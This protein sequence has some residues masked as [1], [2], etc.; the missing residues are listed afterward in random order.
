MKVLYYSA[1]NIRMILNFALLM[2]SSLCFS[3]QSIELS[4]DFNRVYVSET[5]PYS[6]LFQSL[7]HAGFRTSSMLPNWDKESELKIPDN[8]SNWLTKKL[9]LDKLNDL[10]HD[11]KVKAVE[12]SQSDLG[13]Y[14]ERSFII[15][16]YLVGQYKVLVCS[17]HTVTEKTPILMT[18]HGHG[19]TA[20]DA[21]YPFVEDL[22]S[23]GVIVV[24][25][26]F[27]AMQNLHE[28]KISQNLFS[29]G[30]S[31]MGVRIYESLQTLKLIRK[32]YPSDR[33]IGLLGHSGGSTIAHILAWIT[34]AFSVCVTD[35]D[36]NFHRI[37]EQ[38]CCEGIPELY[39]S[40]KWLSDPDVFPG[41]LKKFSYN[42]VPEED[43][44]FEFFME[45]LNPPQDI[46]KLENGEILP[47]NIQVQ[48]NHL[49]VTKNE[50]PEMLKQEIISYL[51]KV[52][53]PVMRD[54]IITKVMS[55]CLRLP[56]SKQPFF[57]F[58]QLSTLKAKISFVSNIS[59]KS[60]TESTR[61]KKLENHITN[62]VFGYPN[63]KQ[64]NSVFTK[65]FTE[66]ARSG[67][68]KFALN[69]LKSST[70]KLSTLNAM[71]SQ[72]VSLAV[73][74][75]LTYDP[76]PVY[77]LDLLPLS[78]EQKIIL[79]AELALKIF[80]D[81]IRNRLLHKISTIAL[82]EVA[83]DKTIL[84]VS[85]LRNLA[86]TSSPNDSSIKNIKLGIGELFRETMLRAGKVFLGRNKIQTLISIASYFEDPE[87]AAVYL[88]VFM[89]NIDS[90]E[91]KTQL[92][93]ALE[94][95]LPK[96][97]TPIFK[98]PFARALMRFYG[99]NKFENKFKYWFMKGLRYCFAETSDFDRIE[100][101]FTMVLET[102]AEYGF[103][104]LVELGM[105]QLP[106]RRF[107][108]HI[109][110]SMLEKTFDS[111]T[112]DLADFLIKRYAS[113]KIVNDYSLRV[114]SSRA[115]YESAAEEMVASFNKFAL[116]EHLEDEFD[117]DDLTQLLDEYRGKTVK[118]IIERGLAYWLDKIYKQSP[119]KHE[120]KILLEVA[121]G[122]RIIKHQPLFQ[123]AKSLLFSA[124][125]KNSSE[126]W[127][128]INLDWVEQLILNNDY[129][130]ALEISKKLV[131]SEFKVS[132]EIF[133]LGSSSFAQNEFSA[134]L[135]SIRS[136]SDIDIRVALILDLLQKILKSNYQMAKSLI[137]ELDDVMSSLS[138]DMK[139]QVSL[140]LTGIFVGAG[141]S[142]V[143]RMFAFEALQLVHES[144]SDQDPPLALVDLFS[145]VRDYSNASMGQLILDRIVAIIDEQEISND[146]IVI[147]MDLLERLIDD[148]HPLK[149]DIVQVLV[150]ASLK[151]L[152][153][154]KSPCAE[155]LKNWPTSHGE[156]VEVMRECRQLLGN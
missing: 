65:L 84:D 6:K 96:I 78:S 50:M 68:P 102:A 134:L 97:K 135:K 124:I 72:D 83:Q 20:S 21:L 62:K 59:T 90:I 31:L 99:E 114:A 11:Q 87:D 70:G 86:N 136:I 138:S 82:K 94:K 81:N 57:L 38:F 122:A 79:G 151:R 155:L 93:R 36:S 139:F 120:V 146:E 147:L 149:V 76:D 106:D 27:R 92:I 152:I 7:R 13:D 71:Q 132:A 15:D 113:T 19:G 80:D 88:T 127:D 40:S 101:K 29:M 2:I 125:S 110:K 133:L 16:D 54:R 85:I 156:S 98:V 77:T 103:Q 63:V 49:F 123:R 118:P 142:R 60:S 47:Q 148:A 115:R 108:E 140:R 14:I 22:L 3:V 116:Q 8:P 121:K 46:E 5:L 45:N 89:E 1:R 153:E 105:S 44:V 145:L 58:D 25:P 61:L 10:N 154:I 12:N 126:S 129:S 67:D 23:E 9:G 30:L 34:N 107:Q 4:T 66:L 53:F 24:I 43:Q 35:H 17:P 150:N 42:F 109:V 130:G 73:K 56:E 28:V 141:Y 64:R 128:N 33:K 91:Y 144:G 131:G 112:A 55:Y 48:L 39:R 26:D 143:S 95:V 37:W 74:R 104:D 51:R 111:G 52:E 100:P 32:L 41:L 18:F 69:F 119:G 117:W 137:S 75:L